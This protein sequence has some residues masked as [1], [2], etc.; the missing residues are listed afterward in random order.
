MPIFGQSDAALVKYFIHSFFFFFF[1]QQM[2]TEHQFGSESYVKVLYSVAN[3]TLQT[4][5]AQRKDFIEP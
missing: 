3:K 5:L 1:I 4:V 2:L